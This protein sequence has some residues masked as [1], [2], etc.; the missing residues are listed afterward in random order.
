MTNCSTPLLVECVRAAAGALLLPVR[1]SL[2]QWVNEKVRLSS[3][4]SVQPGHW[5]CFPYARRK[6]AAQ[7]EGRELI[8]WWEAMAACLSNKRSRGVLLGASGPD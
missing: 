5:Q 8:W 1:I 3:E 4:G 2:S 7:R 6:V